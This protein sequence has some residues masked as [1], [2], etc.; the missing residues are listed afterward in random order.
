M[1]LFAASLEQSMICNYFAEKSS[2][3]VAFSHCLC[4]E[5]LGLNLTVHCSYS[6]QL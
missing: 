3:V 6:T 5:S 2:L 4:I 1:L